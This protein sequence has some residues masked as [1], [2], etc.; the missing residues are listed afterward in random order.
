MF[1]LIFGFLFFY[2][3]LRRRKWNSLYYYVA[4]YVVVL[5][6]LG[7]F[8]NVWQWSD[9]AWGFIPMAN[10]PMGA[11]FFYIGADSVLLRIMRYFD[12]KQILTPLDGKRPDE[13][14]Y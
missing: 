9:Y 5:E 6:L 11:V 1:S 8:F 14:W 13:N 4:L 3:G 7:T 12:R 2:R 10:P